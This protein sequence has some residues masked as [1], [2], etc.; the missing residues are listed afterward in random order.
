MVVRS[1]RGVRGDAQGNRTAIVV[2]EIPYQ[3]NKSSLIE[4][5]SPSWCASKQV[6]G[7]SDL[8]DESDRDG[9]RIVIELKRE[10]T[11]EVVLNH[12]YRFTADADPASG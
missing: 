10:A 11:P 12:L 2:S 8:R 6:E 4:N 5:A 3:V 7:I 1:K 9:M